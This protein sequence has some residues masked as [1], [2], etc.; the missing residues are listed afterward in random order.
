MSSGFASLLHKQIGQI[1][2]VSFLIYAPM[3][4]HSE[5]FS[6]AVEDG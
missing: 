5:M 4:G 1:E 3:M 2:A 6:F